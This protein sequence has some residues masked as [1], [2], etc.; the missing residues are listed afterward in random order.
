[1]LFHFENTKKF[2]FGREGEDEVGV[3]GGAEEKEEEENKEEIDHFQ[4][5]DQSVHNQLR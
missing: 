4:I 5:L 3:T 2:N 1:V